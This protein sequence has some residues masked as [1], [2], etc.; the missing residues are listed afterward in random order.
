MTDR[1]AGTWRSPVDHRRDR[2]RLLLRRR[3]SHNESAAAPGLGGSEAAALS[4]RDVEALSSQCCLGRR[5]QSVGQLAEQFGGARVQG[6]ADL[7]AATTG[8]NDTACAQR[9]QMS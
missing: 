7:G 5:V 9:L 6:V 2:S 4:G 1:G 8:T 3:C